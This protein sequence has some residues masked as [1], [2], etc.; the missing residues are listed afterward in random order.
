MSATNVLS[1]VAK[2]ARLLTSDDVTSARRRREELAVQMQQVTSLYKGL[3]GIEHASKDALQESYNTLR[4]ERE[5]LTRRANPG[6]IVPE[7]YQILEIN[8]LTVRDKDG[9]PALVIWKLDS[10]DFEI[11][12][13][14]SSETDHL[15]VLS[16]KKL[17]EE[18]AKCFNDLA[19]LLKSKVNSSYGGRTTISCKFTGLIPRDVK[20]KIEEARSFFGDDIF[21]IGE[22]GP[23]KIDVV[24]NPKPDPLV[25]G[26]RDGALWL[27]D[28][29]DITPLE[30]MLLDG[31]AT[32]G[33]A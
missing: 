3:L 28:K 7:R 25:V 21:I 24:N 13:R 8:P 9:F 29:F 31:F 27:I 18:L 14:H 4:D 30:Q 12:F 32:K 16:P 22:P 33:E 26:F 20:G 15:S 17:P 5:K 10:P 1:Q 19:K 23:W 11:E 6:G 2:S